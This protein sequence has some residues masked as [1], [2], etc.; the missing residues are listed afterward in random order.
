MNHSPKNLLTARA[1]FFLLVL[2]ANEYAALDDPS[3]PPTTGAHAYR[4][5]VST[6]PS[7]GEEAADG[8][9]DTIVA[10][11]VERKFL[12]P[13]VS[14]TTAP[15]NS[16]SRACHQIEDEASHRSCE[17]ELEVELDRDGSS[18]F[19]AVV[20]GRSV[21]ANGDEAHGS[22]KLTPCTIGLVVCAALALAMLLVVG[23]LYYFLYVC[24]NTEE[25]ERL[26]SGDEDEVETETDETL[27]LDVVKTTSAPSH[28]APS[29]KSASSRAL[30]GG[31]REGESDRGTTTRDQS[32]TAAPASGKK[33]PRSRP[34]QEG[35]RTDGRGTRHSL[36]GEDEKAGEEKTAGSIYAENPEHGS[37]SKLWAA[38]S[39]LLLPSSWL[40][41]T[42]RT[43]EASER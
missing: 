30:L 9:A 6:G 36:S 21:D 16:N 43:N 2:T 13:R 1:A 42:M 4:V 38:I 25:E 41:S 23:L 7:V 28:A 32:G 18:N 35:S 34:R 39:S 37:A 12:A 26:A 3:G 20:H 10:P 14:A 31:A 19:L 17:V 27:D 29:N 5:A 15:A 40:S 22:T 8:L 33:V 11:A 24:K